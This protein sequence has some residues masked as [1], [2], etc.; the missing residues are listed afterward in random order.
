[1]LL[2]FSLLL[3]LVACDRAK[4]NCSDRGIT[5]SNAIVKIAFP[6]TAFSSLMILLDREAISSVFIMLLEE[7]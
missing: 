1:M 6:V 2:H 3:A 4:N 7:I 5:L